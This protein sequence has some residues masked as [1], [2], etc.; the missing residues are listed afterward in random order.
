[1]S[2]TLKV[3]VIGVGGIARVHMPGWEASEHTEVVAGSDINKDILETWGT[4]HGI[5]KLTTDPNELF[6]DPDIDIVD[7]CT[8]NN[9][10]APLSIAALD[11]GK[12][13]L[14]EKPLAPTPAEIRDMIA[15]R[16]RSGKMTGEDE[17]RR[18]TPAA[19]RATADGG[20]RPYI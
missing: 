15:A 19:R 1:M 6:D 11:S 18:G 8:P 16:D 5:T 14:C 10:H 17:A 4:T 13:V 20:H 9:Y 2:K 12:H 3:A 7:V